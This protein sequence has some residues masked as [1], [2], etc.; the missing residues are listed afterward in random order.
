MC[1][2]CAR[3]HGGEGGSCLQSRHRV[4]RL[5]NSHSPAMQSASSDVAEPLADYGHVRIDW[6]SRTLSHLLSA[7][8]APLP[9]SCVDLCFDAEGGGALL[10]VGGE[11]ISL[12][13]LFAHQVL[14]TSSG[15]A[16]LRHRSTGAQIA[17]ETSKTRPEH[18]YTDIRCHSVVRALL[19]RF[20]FRAAGARLW[21]DMPS[22]RPILNPAADKHLNYFLNNHW[23]RWKVVISEHIPEHL[24]LRR[25]LDRSGRTKSWERCL[26][27]PAFSTCGLLIVLCYRA[28][29]GQ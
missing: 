28:S 27:E 19:G 18:A 11:R 12:A 4:R 9:D 10:E 5:G 29:R 7:E 16:W 8:T 6:G 17:V 21:W 23:P 26:R 2:N 14:V 25:A 13:T 22:V 15:E 3:F 24:G 20:L 1:F